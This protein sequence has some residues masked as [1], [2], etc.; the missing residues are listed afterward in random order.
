MGT[1]SPVNADSFKRADPSRRIPSN[2]ILIGYFKNTTSFGTK[3][4]DET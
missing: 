2:G 3:S 4:L 1:D